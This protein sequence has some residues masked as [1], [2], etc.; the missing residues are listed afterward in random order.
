MRH[1]ATSA[2]EH[3]AS[4]AQRGRLQ[5]HQDLRLPGALGPQGTI[6]APVDRAVRELVEREWKTLEKLRQLK[7][8]WERR[9]SAPRTY[10]NSG[11]RRPAPLF[12]RSLRAQAPPVFRKQRRMDGKSP[13]DAGPSE[14]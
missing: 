3:R 2:F 12:R 14:L 7:A 4:N 8:G 9:L 5:L 13:A 11:T 10:H 6:Q 1:T